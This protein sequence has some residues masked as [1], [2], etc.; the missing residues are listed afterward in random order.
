MALCEPVGPAI[1][2]SPG[3]NKGLGSAASPGLVSSTLQT[4]EQCSVAALLSELLENSVDE[5][6]K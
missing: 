1:S 6:Y 2:P 3:G 4:S 5:K